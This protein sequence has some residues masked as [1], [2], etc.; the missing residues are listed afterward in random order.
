MLVLTRNL[1]E[2]IMIGDTI[3]ITIVEI[4]RG[5]VRIGIDAPKELIIQREENINKIPKL[6]KPPTV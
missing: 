4:G 5:R 6:G 2:K 1:N 3:I